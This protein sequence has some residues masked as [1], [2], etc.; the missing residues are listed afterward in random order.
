MI[1]EVSARPAGG[2][3]EAYR[4]SRVVVSERSLKRSKT[5]RQ[6]SSAKLPYR[7]VSPKH[8][9][10]VAGSLLMGDPC[11]GAAGRIYSIQLTRLPSGVL[12]Y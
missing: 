2:F 11:G 9:K 3:C 10:A 8:A 7:L 12:V 1:G 5:E 6:E 4:V